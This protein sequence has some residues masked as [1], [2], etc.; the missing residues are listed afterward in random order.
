MIQVFHITRGFRVVR[1]IA[2]ALT[3]GGLAFSAAGQLEGMPE[4]LPRLDGVA[5]IAGL[6]AP[7]RLERDVAGVASVRGRSY[8]DTLRGLG[9]A[10]GQDRFF[11]MDLMRRVSAGRVSELVGSMAVGSDE[12]ARRLG[13]HR[14][15][16]VVVEQLPPREK[17]W[18]VAYAEG[19]N[20]ALAAAPPAPEYA[21]LGVT[22]ERFTPRD[23]VFILLTMFDMLSTRST[24]ERQT[25]IMRETLPP[26]L[27]AFL[28]PEVTRFDR[29]LIGVAYDDRLPPPPVPGPEVIN[30][31]RM[32]PAPAPVE[33]AASPVGSNGWAVAGSRTSDGR[34]I[35]AND[36]HLMLSVP[37]IWYRAE[38]T[39]ADG[40]A[41]G[42]TLPGTPAILIG[43]N[44]HVAW[45]FTNSAVD[46]QDL[47]IVEPDPDDPGR[48]RTATGWERFEERKEAIAVR[49]AE[50]RPV[51]IRTTRWGP[52][53]GMDHAGRPLALQWTALDADMINFNVLGMAHER[54]LENAIARLRSWWGPSQNAMVASADGRIGW[55]LTG[56]LPTRRGFD[57][58]AP[59]T[60]SRIDVG[61]AGPRAESDR[62][63]LVDPPAGVLFTANNRTVGGPAARGLG[64]AWE[65]GVRAHRIAERLTPARRLDEADLLAIQLDT[66]VAVFDLYRDLLLAVV[67]EDDADPRRMA[68]RAAVAA[69]GGTADA[70]E[71][72]LWLLDRWRRDL[73]QAIIGPL[74]SACREAAPQFVF[75]SASSEEPVRRILETRPPHLLPPPHAD[76]PSFLRATLDATLRTLVS[77]DAIATLDRGWGSVNR[78]R[79]EHPMSRAAPALRPLLDM[80]A[81]PLA[82]HAFA[83][84]VMTPRFGASARLVVSPGHE[85]RGILQTPAGQSGHPLSTFYRTGHDAWLNGRVVPFRA[86]AARHGLTL[87]PPST[88]PPARR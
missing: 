40:W 88:T 14:V 17:A 3:L 46:V 69:W 79:I 25:G 80:P 60:R 75:R 86:G 62:P 84:R 52:V 61:W 83:V 27:V 65:L 76:W 58:R 11:Q 49:G 12:R 24:L 74:V 4:S 56:Y 21:V 59:V 82:G 30:L 41:G 33:P 72:G 37:G 47:V 85:S 23:T 55:V 54:T 10:H 26:P 57:G 29:P 44:G 16:S 31:R 38:L 73:H 2:A 35:L 6:D 68:A 20:A 70:D 50:P 78:A 5:T 71:P 19:V 81:S 1:P 15:A 8:V 51:T 13:F 32:A 28:R 48:Y 39:W 87:T 7:V 53:T 42:L 77:D 18:L 64:D 34:A 9:F 67:G 45:G 43:A 63:V 66:R 22:P 36:P